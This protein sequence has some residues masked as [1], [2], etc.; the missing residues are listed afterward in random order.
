MP[1]RYKQFLNDLPCLLEDGHFI[2]VHA[3]LDMSTESP[4]TQTS[5]ETMLWG[6]GGFFS[7]SDIEGRTIVSGHT[8]RSVEKITASLTKP[9]IQL[10]N[11]AFCCD[12]PNHGHLVALNLDEMQLTFQPWLDGSPARDLFSRAWESF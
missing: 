1:E 12:P 7:D 2:F 10:D 11:G 8:I 3:C 4:V 5:E 9:H 6:N